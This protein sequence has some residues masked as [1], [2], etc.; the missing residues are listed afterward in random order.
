MDVEFPG[1][2]C[3]H[4]ATAEEKRRREA[5]QPPVTDPSHIHKRCTRCGI[6]KPANAFCRNKRSFD[7][8]Y[9][10]C[11]ACVSSKV[12]QASNHLSS[13]LF[14]QAGTCSATLISSRDWA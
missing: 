10:Q 6:E 14:C 5:R 11:R 1:V 12:L 3:K 9:S 13:M 2:Q 8:L 7:G 4:C